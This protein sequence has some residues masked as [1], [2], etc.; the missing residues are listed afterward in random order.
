MLSRVTD[1][2]L[3]P[4]RGG[5]TIAQTLDFSKILPLSHCNGFMVPGDNSGGGRKSWVVK[6]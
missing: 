3:Q 4:E 2:I 5:L 6:P 1:L